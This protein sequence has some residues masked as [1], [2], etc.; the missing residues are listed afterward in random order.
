M[1]A[2]IKQRNPEQ[3]EEVMGL[4]KT[5]FVL[6]PDAETEV[7][8]PY[9]NNK[10]KLGNSQETKFGLTK[11][12][13]ELFENHFGVT[14]DSPE[15]KEFLG[16]YRIVIKHLTTPIDRLKVEHDFNMSILEANGGLGLV[17][18]GKEDDTRRYPFVLVDEETELED[19]VTRKMTRNAAITEL[20]N[21]QVKNKTKMV[22]IAKYLFNLN[23]DFNDIVA[24]D[25]LD[26]YIMG[27]AKNCEIFLQ[28]LKL[29]NEWVDTTVLVK[30]C[31]SYGFIR[32][33]ED[34]YYTNHASG[35]K[36]GR[37]IEEIVKF[38]ND[39][40]NQDQLGIG[41]NTD[42]PYSLRTQLKQKIK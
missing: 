21:L 14:F 35:V 2:F 1:G 38:L 34:Q 29:D 32:K 27:S 23:S 11:K 18:L 36:L 26:E 40:N 4:E 33:G 10:F 7:E 28:T 25:R 19:K 16:N 6:Y 31:M 20:N 17:H 8:I 24:Y 22:N 37:T 3:G 15:G 12:K 13:Q 42:Q 9:V 30:D 5:G 39:P 41:K